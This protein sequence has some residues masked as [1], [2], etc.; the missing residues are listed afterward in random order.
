ML[1][2][3]QLLPVVKYEYQK[4]ISFDVFSIFYIDGYFSAALKWFSI[5][6]KNLEMGR[7]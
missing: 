2:A 3:Q 1:T 4:I 6:K 5:D 7:W